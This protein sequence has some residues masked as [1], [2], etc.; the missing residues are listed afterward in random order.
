[1]QEIYNLF[2]TCLPYV[3][4]DEEEAKEILGNEEN[5]VLEK[6]N[7]ENKLIGVSVVHKNSILLLCVAPEYRN[8]GIGTWLLNES[9]EVIRKAGYEEVVVGA[10][11]EYL[12]PGIPTS[13]RY[14]PA[15]NER[16]DER[17]NDIASNFFEKRGYVHD[18]GDE[19]NCFDMK[20]PLSEFVKEEYGVDTEIDGILYRFA[21]IEDKESLFACTDAACE[22]FTQWY[23]DDEMYTENDYSRVMIA[24]ADGGYQSGKRTGLRRMYNSASGVSREAYCGKYGHYRNKVPA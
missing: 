16:L 6:R 5:T 10:G 2:R 22:E 9:E 12:A 21:T 18:W 11:E 7:E 3:V 24:E 4:R 20:F 15:V 8:R 1:M 14:A 19:C 17:V 23:Q 13:K